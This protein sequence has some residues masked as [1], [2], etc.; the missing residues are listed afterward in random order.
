[1]PAEADKVKMGVCKVV[2]GGVS[3]GYT[4]GGVEVK[5]ETTTKEILVDQ[6]GTTPIGETITGRRVTV[7]VPVAETTLQNLG[8]ALPGAELEGTP[9]GP[10]RL[11]IRGD[12]GLAMA[13]FAK[14]LTLHPLNAPGGSDDFIV[15]RAAPSG[16]ISFAFK[17]DE[18][19]IFTI[20]FRGYV[21]DAA[22]PLVSVGH[23]HESLVLNNPRQTLLF[24]LVL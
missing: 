23:G 3:L 1:M 14:R 17:V 15:H 24:L 22:Q 21:S 6:F 5:L 12:A 7:S 9:N 18:E 13:T 4:K 10:Y 20:E 11:K 16:S 19:R 2:F 8:I